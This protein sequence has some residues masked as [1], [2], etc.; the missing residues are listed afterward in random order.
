M[1]ASS[2]LR[3]CKVWALQ[4]CWTNPSQHRR[5]TVSGHPAG[6]GAQWEVAQADRA[7]TWAKANF[8]IWFTYQSSELRGILSYC[9]GWLE[10]GKSAFDS[11]CDGSPILLLWALSHSGGATLSPLWETSHRVKGREALLS[12]D[13][14]LWS[15]DLIVSRFKISR[16]RK[17]GR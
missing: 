15:K 8:E 17:W 13:N 14:R 1:K 10:P 16:V 7:Q 9:N 12:L 6:V 11:S 5:G 4:V 2:L 3:T